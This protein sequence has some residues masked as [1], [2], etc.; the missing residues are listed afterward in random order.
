MAAPS[1]SLEGKS[2]WLVQSLPVTPRQVL[3]AKLR[4]QLL[5][6]GI[7]VLFCIVCAALIYPYTPIELLAAALVPLSYVLFSAL[8][9]LFV[10][11]KMPILCSAPCDMLFSLWIFRSIGRGCA[12]NNA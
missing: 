12:Q 4:M 8:F 7:P 9:G 11:L 1:V 2:L 5:L 10:G 3:R 6:T